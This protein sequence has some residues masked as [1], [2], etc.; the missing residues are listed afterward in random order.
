MLHPVFS[1][2]VEFVEKYLSKGLHSDK[3]RDII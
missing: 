1:F 2:F 3:K